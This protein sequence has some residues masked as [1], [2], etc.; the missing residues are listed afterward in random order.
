MS[1][2]HHSCS[3]LIACGG[4]QGNGIPTEAL[5]FGGVNSCRTM[6][7]TFTRP[8]ALLCIS[9]EN[10]LV[11]MPGKSLQCGMSCG[12]VSS[13]HRENA[14]EFSFSFLSIFFLGRHVF[15]FIIL[16]IFFCVCVTLYLKNSMRVENKTSLNISK[17]FH[18]LISFW[19]QSDLELSPQE[20]FLSLSLTLW[21][22]TTCSLHYSFH[23]PEG[24]CKALKWVKW[25]QFIFEIPT[26]HHFTE[27]SVSVRCDLLQLQ[28]CREEMANAKSICSHLLRWSLSTVLSN[29]HTHSHTFFSKLCHGQKPNAVIV[30]GH[31]FVLSQLPFDLSEES[32]VPMAIKTRL[33]HSRG[34]HGH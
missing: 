21:A 22:Q 5:H 2:W 6:W 12:F 27:L 16:H 28:N 3:L 29:T 1:G 24:D 14:L 32:G 4:V 17:Y 18:W 15:S 34:F 31:I 13:Q 10:R 23:L 30:S 26:S 8:L 7:G 25:H 20:L 9:Q 33:V 19:S 11:K